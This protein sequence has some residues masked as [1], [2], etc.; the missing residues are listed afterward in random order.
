MTLARSIF[1]SRLAN[2]AALVALL[3]VLTGSLYLQFAIGEQPC[4][5]CMV[6]R[7]GMI[8]LAIGPL[9]NLLWGLKPRNYAFVILASFAGGAGSVR[10]VL[11][12]I[13]NAADPGYGPAILGF[14]MYTWA[15]IVFAIATV[16]VA[17]LLMWDGPLD[18]KEPGL[19]AE[20]GPMRAVALSLFGLVAIYALTIGVS[21]IGECGLQPCPDDPANTAGMP[22]AAFLLILAVIIGGCAAGGWA[23]DR[24]LRRRQTA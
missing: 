12:H 22:G 5:L 7:S 10:Q 9:L 4:P 6:Q 18:A 20:P 3:L 15:A 23:V 24:R 17:L 11:L 19:M 1:L 21:V 8:G 13:D 16:G 2:M 14:H